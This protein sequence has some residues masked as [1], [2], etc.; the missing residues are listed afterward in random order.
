[1]VTGKASNRVANTF[2]ECGKRNDEIKTLWKMSVLVKERGFEKL[3]GQKMSSEQYDRTSNT[4]VRELF[5]NDVLSYMEVV[6]E[7]FKGSKVG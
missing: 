6:L 5:G 4:T 2:K 7:F 1:M 3:F